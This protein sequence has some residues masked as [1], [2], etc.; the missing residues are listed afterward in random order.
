MKKRKRQVVIYFLNFWF[1]FDVILLIILLVLTFLLIKERLYF[2]QMSILFNDYKNLINE[3]LKEYDFKN[4]TD[5]NFSSVSTSD[6]I[7]ILPQNIS[8]KNLKNF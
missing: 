8:Y 5:L 1:V 2:I 4:L 7:Y 3:D 6:V